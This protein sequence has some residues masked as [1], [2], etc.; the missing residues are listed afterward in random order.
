MEH[1]LEVCT[2]CKT[3]ADAKKPETLLIRNE[4]TGELLCPSCYCR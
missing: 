1:E 4:V 2:A 3:P